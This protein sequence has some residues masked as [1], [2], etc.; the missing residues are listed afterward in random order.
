MATYE[1][2]LFTIGAGSG[3]VRASRL[4]SATGAR[5][6]VAEDRDLGGTCVNVGCVPKKLFVYAARFREEIIDAVG[7]GWRVEQPTFDWPTL[8]THKNREIERLG[9]LYERVLSN[10]GVEII[11]G[12]ATIIDP[13][14]VE[15]AG[16]RYTCERILVATG[17]RPVVPDVPGAEHS[18]T[19]NE[20]FFLKKLPKRMAIVGGG[21][22][23]I[24]FAGIFANLGV[25]VTLLYRGHLF[26]RGFDDDIRAFLADQL[27]SK[28]IDLRFNSPILSIKKT[29][30]HLVVDSGHRP[31]LK[32][33]AVMMATGRRPATADLGLE[34]AGVALSER[35]A[36]IV[37][38]HFRSSVPS[39]FA[40]GDVIDRVAL[41]P[42]AI[43]EGVA[44]VATHFNNTPTTVSYENI[45]TAVF[46]QPP[47][48]TVG[49]SE[50][51]AHNRYGAVDVYTST[52]TP[53]KNTLAGRNEKIL[54]K[55]IVHPETDRVLGVHMVGP[56][57]PEII[58]SL[59]VALQCGATKAQ[60]DA[61][62]AL[63]PSIAEEFVTMRQK[64][65][66]VEADRLR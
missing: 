54:M 36:I 43:T 4:A 29:G 2:D 33:D 17:G 51:V 42:V 66:S 1:Y 55:M 49:I 39:I 7:Y 9:R 64:R 63:H 35:G 8:V 57:S 45:P 38:D 23:A 47:L 16:K 11:E 59:A 14:C 53:M 52:F 27:S 28:S 62:M 58:Q 20:A 24:E 32:V 41:T 44:F 6:A 21:Y 46:S 22:I 37:D 19:S 13:H 30:R 48:A 25:D 65:A 10:A 15:V 12:R 50:H 34:A 18:F 60:F 40:I 56:D 61:T 31:G 5:V 3:G 26:L